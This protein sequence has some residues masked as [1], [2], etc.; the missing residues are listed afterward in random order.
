MFLALNS[1]L[2]TKKVDVNTHTAQLN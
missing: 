1:S 2:F